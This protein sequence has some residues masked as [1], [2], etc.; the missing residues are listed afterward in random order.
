M[1]PVPSAGWAYEVADTKLARETRAD[2]LQR[3]GLYCETLARIRV[4]CRAFPCGH[5]ERQPRPSRISGGRLT[6]LT[7]A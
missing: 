6:P 7:F 2:H 4:V 3:R 1:L 5:A